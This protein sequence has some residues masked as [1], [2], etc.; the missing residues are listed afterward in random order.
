VGAAGNGVPRPSTAK[1]I[2]VWART[3]E[4]AASNAA[5]ATCSASGGSEPSQ[6]VSQYGTRT[7]IT[8]GSPTVNTKLPTAAP[9]LVTTGA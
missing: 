9:P 2:T 1:R 6:P 7:P 8:P 5:P 4:P 3:P